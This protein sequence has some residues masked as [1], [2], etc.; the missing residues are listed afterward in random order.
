[1]DGILFKV[2]CSMVWWIN[3]QCANKQKKILPL[4]KGKGT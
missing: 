2:Y 1:M 3:Y 4:Q